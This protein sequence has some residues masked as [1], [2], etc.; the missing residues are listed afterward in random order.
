MTE[1]ATPL[2]TAISL[3]A[4]ESAVLTRSGLTPIGKD[5]S[6]G[7]VLG[8]SMITFGI[9]FLV[10]HYSL[11]NEIRK[12][13]P[14]IKVSPGLSTLAM[15]IP[16]ANC[17]AAYGT[18]ARLRQMQLDEGQTDTTSPVVALLLFM[19]L[20]IGYPLYIASQAREHWHAHRRADRLAA[21]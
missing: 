7:A 15:C 8:L 6:P 11:N 14:D 10:W 19:F 5:R 4:S 16:I 12:H 1:T 20:G 18:A 17:V 13:N 21:A 9:Y 3:P 2:Q